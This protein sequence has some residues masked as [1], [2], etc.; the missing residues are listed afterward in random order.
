MNRVLF[1][2]FLLGIFTAVALGQEED[3]DGDNEG[4]DIRVKPTIP[5]M[6]LTSAGMKPTTEMLLMSFTTV[7][8]CPD[9]YPEG[10]SFRC[11]VT[12]GP[13]FPVVVFRVAGKVYQ[14]ERVAPYYLQ[15]DTPIKVRPFLYQDVTGGMLSGGRIR[16][17]C[18]VRM[19]LPV[20][21][22]LVTQC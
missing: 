9:D 21:I 5:R 13:D 2:L 18:R 19:R 11:D 17:A 12:T 22:D 6:F 7:T 15:G 16:I 8:V 3:T 4:E 10:F 1:S 14:K 20:W